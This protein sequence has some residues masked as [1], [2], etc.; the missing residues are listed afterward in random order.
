[1]CHT[2]ITDYKK[3]SVVAVSADGRCDRF[4]DC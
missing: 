1:M 3:C 4:R 2:C